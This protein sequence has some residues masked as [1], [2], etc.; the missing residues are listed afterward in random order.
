M[1]FIGANDTAIQARAGSS[2]P[3]ALDG[4]FLIWRGASGRA[5]AFSPLDEDGPLEDALLIAVR[6]DRDGRPIG[7]RP[8]S[9]G[10]VRSGEIWAHHLAATPAARHSAALDLLAGGR[11]PEAFGA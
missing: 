8:V 4:R 6:R 10:P 9:G 11:A 2:C 1:A 3:S 7:A 5:Y